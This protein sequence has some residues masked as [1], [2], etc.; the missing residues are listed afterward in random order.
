[1]AKGDTVLGLIDLFITMMSNCVMRRK[2]FFGFCPFASIHL[3]INLGSLGGALTSAK[4]AVSTW[5]GSF[6][7]PKNM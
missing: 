2:L 5:F 7:G 3:I 4:S 1:M 6:T